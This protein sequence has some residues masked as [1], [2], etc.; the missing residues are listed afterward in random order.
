MS[1]TTTA[2]LLIIFLIYF[3]TKAI[4]ILRPHEK[5]LLERLGRFQGIK[6]AG[7]HFMWPFMDHIE[8]LDMR[9]LVIDVPPQK[10]ITNDNVVVV[11]DAVIYYQ[12]TDPYKV[13][14]NV[15]NYHMASTKLAQ[16][17][18]RNLIG[19]LKLDETL[20]SR[21][22]VNAQLREILDEATDKWGIKVNRVEIQKIDPP[23]DITSAMHKQMKAEREKRAQILDAEG[24]K[25]SLILNAEGEKQSLI[26]RAMGDAEA[27]RQV[28]QAERDRYIYEANGKAQALGTVFTSI[29]QSDV[30]KNILSIQFLDTLRTILAENSKTIVLPIEFSELITGLK[31]EGATGSMMEP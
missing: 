15:T 24:V 13:R 1:F 10:V 29:R 16:T 28:A 26:Q 7:I 25:Q 31:K 12:V 20:T 5:G 14:Y 11:V 3:G 21:E 8:K 30:D 18:L 22:K 17:N 6:E 19:E 2:V 23:E 4:I 9:E 27:I